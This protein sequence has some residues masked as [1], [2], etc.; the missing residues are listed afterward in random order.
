MRFSIISFCLST[1]ASLG[2]FAQSIDTTVYAHRGFR[3]LS[4]ENT[5]PAMFK[6]LDMGADVL[7]MDIAF[8]LDKEVIISHDPW[9]DSLITLDSSGKPIPKGKGLPLY[10]MS[11]E[12]ILKYDV[13]SQKHR[14][15]PKQDNFPARIPRLID[16]IDSVEAYA[17][18][19]KFPAPHY[20]IETKSSKSRDNQVQPAPEEF[21]RRLMDIIYEKGIEDRVIIQSFDVRTLEIIHR[22]HPQIVTMLNVTKGGLQEN[23]ARM[24][25]VP[26]YYAPIPS[27]INQDL[28]K[29][30]KEKGIKILCGNVN[31]KHEIDRVMALGVTEYCSDYPYLKMPK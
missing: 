12:S 4:P 11:Y 1:L 6:A 19:R 5:V 18:K 14:G 2:C 26:D 16:L 15:F 27:L 29:Q 7:E 20:S 31:E 30:C 3:G 28:V 17:Y 8:S 9:L 13:G 10:E 24:T 25:F 23:L 22:D 21:V